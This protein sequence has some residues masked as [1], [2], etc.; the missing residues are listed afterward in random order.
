MDS[1]NSYSDN[2]DRESERI[3]FVFINLIK[4]EGTESLAPYLKTDLNLKLGLPSRINS[5]WKASKK[6][7]I[8]RNVIAK[9]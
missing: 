5:P 4:L 8:L 3:T 2:S 1:D 9:K 6:K 7:D